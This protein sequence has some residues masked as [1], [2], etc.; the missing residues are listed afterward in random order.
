MGQG[1]GRRPVLEFEQLV[2]VFFSENGSRED[3]GAAEPDLEAVE[4]VL[5]RATD[6]TA[7][8]RAG[9]TPAPPR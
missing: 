1:A 8:W 5:R 9:V 2:K 3:P 7:R 6:R 4:A